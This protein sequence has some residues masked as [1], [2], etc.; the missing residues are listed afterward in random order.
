M[1]LTIINKELHEDCVTDD[2]ESS[3]YHIVCFPSISCKKHSDKD[4][5]YLVNIYDSYPNVSYYA[6]HSAGKRAKPGTMKVTHMNGGKSGII[7]F[8]IKVY[9][10]DE[11]SY[12][13]DSNVLRIKHF[14]TCLDQVS[15]SIRINKLIM[16]LPAKDKY[17]LKEYIVVINDFI[18]IYKLKN[19]TEPEII[20][21]IGDLEQPDILT[22]NELLTKTIRPVAKTNVT[23]KVKANANA[24]ASSKNTIDHGNGNGNGNVVFK[25]DISE[26]EIV[27]PDEALY[28][29]DFAVL[30]SI[31]QISNNGVLQYFPNDN[32]WLSITSDQ[33]LQELSISV[34]NKIGNVI[35]N[36]DVYPPPEDIFNAFSYV[37][38][39]PKVVLLGQDPYHGKGQA[40]GLS[41]SVKKGI[42]PPPS[43]Q[44]IYKALEADADLTPA[45]LTP[46]HGCLT[47]WAEQGVIMLNTGLTV[48]SKQPGSHIDHW[49]AFTDR[50]IELLSTKYSNLVFILWGTKAKV[51]KTFIKGDH[52]IL[53]Y[54]HPSPMARND[55][56]KNCKNFSE[57]NQYLIKV[58]KQPIDW[59][60]L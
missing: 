7:N 43:L 32:R 49:T 26:A 14:K 9:I 60:L 41:F 58:G 23:V 42:K 36:D 51:K 33:K 59:N 38:T 28:E 4:P 55:F 16:Q 8:Y 10:S 57:T 12:P 34:D 13:N 39:E 24:N 31:K 15:D 25:L 2:L 47:G 19:G 45:F 20:L 1:T 52:L 50:L 18:P 29:M 40:H 44:N 53:E 6:E 27:N 11:A 48:I 46:K 54:G 56:A 22:N 30:D 17:D 21:Y 5:K 3:D 37:K 35:G